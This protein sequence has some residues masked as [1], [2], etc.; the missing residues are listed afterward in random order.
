MVVAL[1]M[2]LSGAYQHGFSRTLVYPLCYRGF[3]FQYQLDINPTREHEK[4]VKSPICGQ[5]PFRGD[6][7]WGKSTDLHI[8]KEESLYRSNGDCMI[9]GERNFFFCH[10]SPQLVLLLVA[11]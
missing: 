8:C 6:F 7:G 4:W 11:W 5:T 1:W 2:V 10:F 9:E 3:P